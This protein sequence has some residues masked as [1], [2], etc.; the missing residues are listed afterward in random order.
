MYIFHVSNGDML[1]AKVYMILLFSSFQWHEGK[2]ERERERE[3]VKG[4]GK[5]GRE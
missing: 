3:E 1:A 2:R 4:A 5:T